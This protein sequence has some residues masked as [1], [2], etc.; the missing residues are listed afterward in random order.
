M[1]I[2]KNY[3]HLLSTIIEN[4]E[5]KKDRTGIGTKSI[6]GWQMKFDLSKGFPLITTKKLHQLLTYDC[7]LRLPQ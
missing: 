5:E 1:V 2:V 6:F 4:G 7:L 3:L